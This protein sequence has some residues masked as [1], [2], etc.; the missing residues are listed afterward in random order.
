MQG[1]LSTA[2]LVP[3]TP[4]SES[5]GN[6]SSLIDTLLL[7]SSKKQPYFLISLGTTAYLVALTVLL[8][9]DFSPPPMMIEAPFEMAYEEAT[10]EP[11][12]TVPSPVEE[13]PPEPVPEQHPEPPPPPP[14]AEKPPE[15]I[16]EP[17]PEPP[18]PVAEKAPE[19]VAAVEPPPPPKPPEPKAEPVK[20]EPPKPVENQRSEKPKPKPRPRTAHTAGAVPSD[21]ANKVYQRINRI[22]GNTFPRIALAQK[23]VRI[24][25]VITIGASGQLISKSVSSSGIPAIDRAVSEAL[26]RSAPFP[27]PPNLGAS[28]YRISGAIVYRVH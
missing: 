19:P 7:I 3:A 5:D 11:P 6:V 24:G 10:P 9:V 12:E 14:V 17:L 13:K 4:A 25:Y 23:S 26:T 2:L 22:A 21:Y 28:S 18:P 1:V 16:A 15:P 27:A 8:M 20:E